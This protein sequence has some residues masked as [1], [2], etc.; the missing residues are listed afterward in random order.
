MIK[1]KFGMSALNITQG[2]YNSYSHAYWNADDLA[3]KTPSIENIYATCD[4][5]VIGVFPYETT[6]FAN[7][8][9]M[10]DRSNDISISFTHID[11]LLDTH[12]VGHK[13][14]NG[15]L[16]YKE[17]TK[18][19]AT[20][21][22][23][24]H[25]LAK[26]RIPSKTKYS[27]GWSLSD[28]NTVNFED[29][30]FID[31][32][33]E[34][35]NCPYEIERRTSGMIAIKYG[36]STIKYNGANYKVI[37]GDAEKG[38]K[39]RLLT[40]NQNEVKDIMDFDSDD[41]IILG[42]VNCNYF[43]MADYTHYGIEYD[44]ELDQYK[45]TLQNPN[46]LAYTIHEDREE[47]EYCNNYE[48]KGKVAFSPYAVRIHNGEAD[49]VWWSSQY[50]DKDDTPNTQTFG[51]KINDDW[52]IGVV[53]N[54]MPREVKNFGVACGASELFLLDSGGSTQLVSMTSGKR[55]KVVYTG[56][57]I[58][59]VLCIA[60]NNVIDEDEDGTGAGGTEYDR[61]IKELSQ[62]VEFLKEENE[63]LR[64]KLSRIKGVLNE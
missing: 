59:D 17:G 53:D 14:K 31:E 34:V 8:V 35:I 18:G 61:L 33:I 19:R 36:L 58:A 13:Y 27:Y 40:C 48:Y 46:V 28:K 47:V 42:M 5:E 16:I 49:H 26:G 55:E 11:N 10:Y 63:T 15:D 6:G 50:G 45:Q 1:R 51:M 22:H 57:K 29:Y 54:A 4:L 44:A 25:E 43:D 39:M 60:K 38:Y 2:R 24:H 52:C 23:C 30:Y 9:I 37:R 62:Q 21:A 3:G 64:S 12:Y 32:T 41:L 20:G 56:R 7:T